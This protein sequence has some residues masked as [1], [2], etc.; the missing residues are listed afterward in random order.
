MYWEHM[1]ILCFESPFDTFEPMGPFLWSWLHKS[2]TSPPH[3]A[4][5]S[6]A[7][8]GMLNFWIFLSAN[9]LS[10]V[11][12][13][14]IICQSFLATSP[15][16]DVFCVMTCQN[17]WVI[18]V[19][20]TRAVHL[21]GTIKLTRGRLTNTLAFPF[22]DFLSV[23]HSEVMGCHSKSMWVSLDR[24]GCTETQ[25]SSQALAQ[26]S[27]SKRTQVVLKMSEYNTEHKTM[28]HMR[29]KELTLFLWAFCAYILSYSIAEKL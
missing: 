13:H 25:L 27:K 19:S 15:F 12:P 21:G 10:R 18:V 11:T 1:I 7:R 26:K 24:A 16:S 28:W 9:H 8:S 14:Y 23:F 22:I 4:Y 2:E 20:R 3:T 17:T 5:M 6:H 29:N